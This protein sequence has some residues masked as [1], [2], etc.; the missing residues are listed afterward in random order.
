MRNSAARISSTT[1]AV[2]ASRWRI[3]HFHDLARSSSFKRAS[4]VTLDVFDT[5]LRRLVARPKDV[6]LLAAHRILQQG[7]DTIDPCHVARIRESSELRARAQS[8]VHEVTLDDI[9]SHF[10]AELSPEL[11]EALRTEEIATEKDVCYANPDIL[12]LYQELQRRNIPVAFVSDTYLPHEMVANLLVDSGYSSDHQLFVSN[13]F[14]STKSNGKLFLD[15]TEHLTVDVDRICHLGDNLISD[16]VNARRAGWHGFWYRAPSLSLKI[17]ADSS[18]YLRQS[19]QTGIAR[20]LQQNDQRPSNSVWQKIAIEVAAP[21]YLGFA[22]WLIDQLR[23]AAVDKIYFCARDGKIVK[24]VYDRL[25]RNNPDLPPST[26]LMISRRSLVFASLDSLG[27]EELKF[28]ATNWADL[29]L[30]DYLTR[31]GLKAEEC[32]RVVEK[33]GLT[34]DTVVTNENREELKH[35]FQSLTENILAIARAE[36]KLLLQY[37]EEQGCLSAKRIG[38][39][40]IGWHGSLQQAFAKVVRPLNPEIEIRGYYV[41]TS[42]TF[43]ERGSSFGSVT[44]WLLNN[45]EPRKRRAVLSGLPVLELLFTAQHGSVL[46]YRAA[47]EGTQAVLHEDGDTREYSLAA[48]EIQANA[49]AFIDQYIKASGHSPPLKFGVAE[50]FGAFRR[51]AE[52]PTR[53]EASAIG[54]L[55]H[56]DGFGETKS[57]RPL[58]KPPSFAHVLMNPRRLRDDF[59]DSHWQFGYLGRIA[60]PSA[61]SAILRGWRMAS[62][63]SV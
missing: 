56:I 18:S 5:A 8:H 15:L 20:S 25:R 42:K 52:T 40:D 37:L 29:K 7:W 45:G 57:G 47:P 2:H 54:D 26:Y 4:L 10:S 59:M 36:R 1:K 17:R 13:A 12:P 53:V 19:L 49:L 50:V 22:Q 11:A 63:R 43:K 27:E 60:G 55:V 3:R 21:L 32:A 16:V 48:A 30:R 31:I 51:L 6:F 39:C 28:L 34:L 33:H 24:E 35:V 44:G 23:T 46:G 9:Y 58:A 62:G 41:G 14:N 38:F 61:M